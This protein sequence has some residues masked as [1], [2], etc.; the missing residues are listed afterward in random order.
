MDH[1]RHINREIIQQKN[2]LQKLRAL[3]Q[4]RVRQAPGLPSLTPQDAQER[5]AVQLRELEESA[6]RH[7]EKCLEEA[8]A[9]QDVIQSRPLASKARAFSKDSRSG[10]RPV[11][12]RTKQP[13]QEQARKIL[14]EASPL[15]ARLLLEVLQEE[16]TPRSARLDCAKEVLN[17]VYGRSQQLLPPQEEH[18]LEVVLEEEAEKD[19]Q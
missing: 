5:Y 6:A 11:S 8:Q 15:A 19:A 2:R 9:L 3:R 18:R 14:V 4:G 10:R 7:L 12:P 17:R 13:P 16:D 1:L